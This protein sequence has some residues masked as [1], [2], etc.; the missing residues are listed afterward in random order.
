MRVK[1]NQPRLLE[2]LAG[3]CAVQAPIDH[4]DTPVLLAAVPA[5]VRRLVPVD[6]VPLGAQRDQ[7][8]TQARL[9]VLHPH[10]ERV[11]GRR[12]DGEGFFGSA[13]RRR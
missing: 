12:R 8:V 11:A 5:A 2:S 6:R 13:G 1:D 4:L 10:Q 3:L 7:G 9:V